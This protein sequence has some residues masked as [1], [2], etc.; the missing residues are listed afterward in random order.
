MRKVN[1]TT[2]NP[3]LQLPFP[4]L[5]LLQ[6]HISWNTTHRIC[7]QYAMYI[8]LFYLQGWLTGSSRQGHKHIFITQQQLQAITTSS[9]L[10]APTL[11]WL[12]AMSVLSF[13]PQV[14]V[15]LNISGFL[16]STT[17]SIA[18][19]LILT[20]ELQHTFSRSPDRSGDLK[21]H[22]FPKKSLEGILPWK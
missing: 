16:Q 14:H 15:Q 11:S 1:R 22:K 19:C 6:K 10:C 21:R 20:G 9:F 3:M 2:P 7:I 4:R 5:T 12:W 13:A 17:V 18:N 8:N